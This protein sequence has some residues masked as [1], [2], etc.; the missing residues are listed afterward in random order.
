[1]TACRPCNSRKKDRDRKAYVRSLSANVRG[2]SA[3][4]TGQDGTDDEQKKTPTPHK[5]TT[6]PTEPKGSSGGVTRARPKAKH[7]I[8]EDFEFTERLRAYAVSKEIPD[9]ERFFE[10]FKNHYLAT[11]EPWLDWNRVF[12]KWCSSSITQ[13]DVMREAQEKARLRKANQANG[14]RGDGAVAYLRQ[15]FPEYDEYLNNKSRKTTPDA[16]YGGSGFD[17]SDANQ[18]PGGGTVRYLHFAGKG[19]PDGGDT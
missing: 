14:R 6:P 13:R 11:G 7:P 8:P 5:K 3:D 10:H 4:K 2:K 12:Y 19:D 15:E 16:G 1:V 18:S 17:G 9:P